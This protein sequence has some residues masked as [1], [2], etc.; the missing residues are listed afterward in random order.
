ML[1]QLI[2]NIFPSGIRAEESFG[3]RQTFIVLHNYFE[4]VPDWRRRVDVVERNGTQILNVYAFLRFMN[5]EYY[6]GKLHVAQ[7]EHATYRLWE[8]E[9]SIFHR[10]KMPHLNKDEQHNEVISIFNEAFRQNWIFIFRM[11][12]E[13]RRSGDIFRETLLPNIS[14]QRTLYYMIANYKRE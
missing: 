12:G 10:W 4:Y 13:R 9:S 3:T 11:R 1:L 2:Y 8:K 5:V 14:S 7:L 6:R